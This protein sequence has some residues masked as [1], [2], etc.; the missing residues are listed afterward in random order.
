MKNLIR[1]NSDTNFFFEN[2]YINL[3]NTN[4]NKL[5]TIKNFQNKEEFIKKK[6][7]YIIILET[8]HQKKTEMLLE[9][10]I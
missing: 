3:I 10:Y 6:S 5:K 2:A 4:I 1:S 9:S 8:V 7:K